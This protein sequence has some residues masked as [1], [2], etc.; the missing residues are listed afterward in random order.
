MPAHIVSVW[1]LAQVR[2]HAGRGKGCAVGRGAY[3]SSGVRVGRQSKRPT[4]SPH[5]ADLIERAY[6]DLTDARGAAHRGGARAPAVSGVVPLI[7]EWRS[8]GDPVRVHDPLDS[9]DE[10]HSLGFRPHALSVTVDAAPLRTDRLVFA[11]LA[12]QHLSGVRVIIHGQA[13]VGAFGSAHKRVLGRRA[14][15]PDTRP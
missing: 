10:L 8:R 7:E 14:G 5:G 9:A 12:A 13:V 6:G 11:M 1:F 3:I 2:E 4:P 15:A